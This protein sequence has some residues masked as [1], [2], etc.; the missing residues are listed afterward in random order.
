MQDVMTPTW[1]EVNT[2]VVLGLAALAFIV[3][4]FIK[5]KQEEKRTVTWVR[6]W[7]EY[8]S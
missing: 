1:A 7:E 8:K 5:G 4:I 6:D 3:F 2:C